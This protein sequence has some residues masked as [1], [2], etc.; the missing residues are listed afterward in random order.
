MIKISETLCSLSEAARLRP[1]RKDGRATHLS[2]VYRWISR[3]IHGVTLE[4]I[5]IGGTTYTSKEALQRFANRLTP[6]SVST[7]RSNT[8]RNRRRQQSV[9]QKLQELGI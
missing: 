4:S 5:R 2:T 7:P 1:L 8:A 9:E 6:E 3:G